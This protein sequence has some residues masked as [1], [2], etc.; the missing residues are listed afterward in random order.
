METSHLAIGNLAIG[1][2]VATKLSQRS[3]EVYDERVGI[4]P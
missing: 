4:L 3:E 1:N 2:L